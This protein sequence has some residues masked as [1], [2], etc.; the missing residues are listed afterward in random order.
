[1]KFSRSV[2][3]SVSQVAWLTGMSEANVCRAVRVGTLPVVRLR[4]RVLVPACAV[5]ELTDSRNGGESQ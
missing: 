5:A 1:M 2:F 3:L 4:G